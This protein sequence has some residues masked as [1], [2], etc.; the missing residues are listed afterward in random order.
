MDAASAAEAYEQWGWVDAHDRFF[1]MDLMRRAAAG[2]SAE[3]FGALAVD[4]DGEARRYG[5]HRVAH[6][7][8]AGLPQRHRVLLDAYVTGVNRRLAEPGRP[9]EYWLLRSRPQPWTPEDSLLVQL[10]LYQQ[11]ALDEAG[12]RLEF[13]VRRTLLPAVADF[14]TARGDPFSADPDHGRTVPLDELRDVLKS[15]SD[16]PVRPTVELTAVTGSNCWAVG[17]ARTA[18][19]V[20]LLVNDMHLGY[21][22][23]PV[24]HRVDVRYPGG[25]GVGFAVPGVPL[26]VS[27]S[28]GRVAWGVANVPGDTTRLVPLSADEDLRERVEEIAVRKAAPRTVTLAEC[29][30]GIPVAD[31]VLGVPAVVVWAATSAHNTDLGWLDLLGASDVG[32]FVRIVQHSGSLPLAVI[33]VDRSEIV[34]TVSGRFPEWDGDGR[35]RGVRPPARLPIHRAGADG[36]AVW[37][38]DPPAAELGADVG[39]NYPASYRRHRI[40]QRL[41][42]RDDWSEGAMA[43][44][45]LDDDAGFFAFYRDLAWRGLPH[46]DAGVRAE[47]TSILDEWDGRS[48]ANSAAFGVLLEF[49]RRLVCAVF[50]RILCGCRDRDSQLRY[51]WRNPEPTLRALLSAPDELASWFGSADWAQ[52]IG[53]HL[54][55]AASSIRRDGRALSQVRWADLLPQRLRHPMSG[56]PVTA[57]FNLP[58]LRG[59]GGPESI[60]ATGVDS[61][62]V[63]RLVVAP[64]EEAHG[65]AG[66]PGGQSGAPWSVYYRDQHR[67]W[68]RQRLDPLVPTA[69]A[70]RRPPRASVRRPGAGPNA[71]R[72]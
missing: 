61:G 55:D 13:V 12:A 56:T 29:D 25:R 59:D 58:V 43:A 48:S 30:A 40:A 24:F 36:L 18:R 51:A 42:A 35:I 52:F 41:Q 64:G 69:V 23:P 2:R 65:L 72:A 45:Q 63:Q 17:G 67:S 34:Q 16:V 49:R 47:L 26:L 28:N 39:R 57:W 33:A 21:T 3:L 53:R 15:T 44:L 10:F 71:V 68:R 31:P 22:A 70:M 4:A 62:P 9:L 27:G 14:L 46:M 20:P 11:L 66:M 1:Q 6:E 37:A 60:L 7:A 38:N 19:G 5:L 32:E 50:D 8:A 54:G